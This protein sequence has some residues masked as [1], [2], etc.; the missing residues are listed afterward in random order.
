M[1]ELRQLVTELQM[2]V[3]QLNETLATRDAR[4]AELEKLLGE[5]R[6]SWKCQ[7]APFS[8]GEPNDEP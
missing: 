6:R 5:S 1:A 8:K 7:A 2:T 3:S 4:I